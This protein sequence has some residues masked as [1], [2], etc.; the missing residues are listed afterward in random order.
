MIVDD[1]IGTKTLHHLSH[2]KKNVKITI[3]SDNATRPKLSLAEYNDFINENLGRTITFIQSLHRAHD[4]F[5]VLD[6]GTKDMKVYHCGAS[7]KDAGN[8]ITTITRIIDIDDYKA[9]IKA[10][11]GNPLLVLK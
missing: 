6:D 11:F 3:I 7:S 1:Y 4:R 9:M 8:R 2:S 5:I 10:M